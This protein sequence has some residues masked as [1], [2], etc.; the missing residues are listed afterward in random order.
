MRS[1]VVSAVAALFFAC[2]GDATP[3]IKPPPPPD[4]PAQPVATTDPD[5]TPTAT[6]VAPKPKLEDLESSAIKALGDAI[7]ARDAKKASELY[8]TE[9]PV[10]IYGQ[11]DIAGREAIAADYQKW[12]DAFGDLKMQVGR[13]ITKGD[14]AI[15]E[16]AFGGTHT[17]DFGGAKAT[18]RPLG[19]QGVSVV[20]FNIDGLVSKEHRILDIA[21]VIA[22]DDKKAKAGSFRAPPPLPVNIE[23]HT[24]KGGGEEEKLSDVARAMFAA[25]DAKKEADFV[26]LFADDAVF[27]DLAQPQPYKGSKEMKAAFAS[28]MKA[29]PDAKSSTTTFAAD[30]LVATEGDLTQT[31]KDKTL[32]IHFVTVL[33]IKGGKIARATRYT[34]TKELRDQL[35]PP[36]PAAKKPAK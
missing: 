7:A 26:A 22:Q 34:T 1:F 14:M 4:P 17:G 21:T 11:G 25:L 19:A 16:W 5:P 32:K 30:D 35:H 6:P 18:Q 8:T 13:V 24:S 9:A 15:I 28:L 12:L 3:P 33:Q 2:G 23:S 31:Q 29:L 10:T 20:W 27:D 36:P